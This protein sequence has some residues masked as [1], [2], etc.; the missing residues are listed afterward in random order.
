[1]PFKRQNNEKRRKNQREVKDADI[2]AIINI[3]KYEV[4][5]RIFKMLK[6]RIEEL[7]QYNNIDKRG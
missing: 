7:Q 4:L 6:K 2:S 1:M 5:K 3:G